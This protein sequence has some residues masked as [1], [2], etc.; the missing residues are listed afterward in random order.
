MKIL[1]V[2]AGATGGYFGACL[3]RAGRDVSF[4]VREKRAEFLQARGLRIAD[5]GHVSRIEPK[6]LTAQTLDKT[7]DVVILTVKATGLKQAIADMAPAVGAQTLIIPFLNGMAHMDA[8]GAAFGTEKVLGSVIHLV[9]TINSDGDI[10]ILN[11]LA[12][13]TVGEQRGEF[14]SRIQ[15]VLAEISVSGYDSLAVPN[16]LSA[17]WHKWA[18]ITA[19]GVVTCLMRGSVGD[20]AAVQGGDVFVASVLAEV[21]GVSA[22]AGFP[23]P[24]EENA[25]SLAFLTQPGSTFTSSLYRDVTAG[26]AHEGEHIIGDF[27]RRA[28]TYEVATPLLDLALMQLRVHDIAV[29]RKG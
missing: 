17:M 7:F 12:R 13:W 11:P 26:L 4:L 8:L 23:V 19:A 3:A 28:A 14:T 18:F 10:E 25:N 21:A 9:S 5:T 29:L 16:G 24:E 20:I 2:G 27:A 22:A 1:V 15:A 6:L